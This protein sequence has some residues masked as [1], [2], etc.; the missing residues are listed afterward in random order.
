[1]LMD[2]ALTQLSAIGASE[3]LSDSVVDD[4]AVV[5]PLGVLSMLPVLSPMTR[6]LLADVPKKLSKVRLAKVGVPLLPSMALSPRRTL[7]SSADAA[8]LPVLVTVTVG[9]PSSWVGLL[10]VMLAMVQTVLAAVRP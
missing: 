7:T 1:K 10:L 3:K 9:L 8:S 4:P 2:S 6:N 5:P